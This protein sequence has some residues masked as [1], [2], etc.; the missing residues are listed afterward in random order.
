MLT[1]T[2]TPEENLRE[3]EEDLREEDEEDIREDL[4]CLNLM[5]NHASHI[6]SLY[7]RMLWKFVRK[8]ASSPRRAS[9]V[10]GLVRLLLSR[11]KAEVERAA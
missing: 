2:S 5:R 1:R 3:L 6:R 9:A 10:F 8:I 7:R 11:P 4:R